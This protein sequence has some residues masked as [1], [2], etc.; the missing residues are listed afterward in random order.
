M[1][2]LLFCE[3]STDETGF[4]F[5]VLLALAGS[6]GFFMLRFGWL[7]GAIIGASIPIAHS[8][9]L[10]SDRLAP[11]YQKHPPKAEDC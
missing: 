11:A 10:C 2:L 9:S 3:W 4:I 8:V 1:A 6:I 7:G 5:A